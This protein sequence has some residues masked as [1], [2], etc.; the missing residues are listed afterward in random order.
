MYKLGVDV[1]STYVKYCILSES[2]D[3]VLLQS[4][5][6]PIHQK[7]YFSQKYN[8]LNRAFPGT[9]AVS[10]GYGKNNYPDSVRI[11]ELVALAKGA[12]YLNS[13]ADIVLDIGGQD[14]KIIRQTNGKLTD[15]FINDKCAAGCGIFLV[16]VC[17]L[18]DIE[19]E[20]I[21]L[22]DVEQPTINLSSKC[23]V[24]AQTEIVELIANNVD[25]NQILYSV[26]WQILVQAKSLLRKVNGKK[27]MLSGGLSK[28]KGIASFAKKCFGIEVIVCEYAAYLSA[29]G[30][31]L[32]VSE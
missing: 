18:L 14:T 3:I 12:Y 27:I 32:S 26:I 22:T 25:V 28:I 24:F 20:S 4:E 6:T 11:N 2:N 23:A 7:E 31:A 13:D 21:D 1:G 29:I 30:S 8:E 19:F 10:C 15:F 17:T 16:H 5:K 9:K